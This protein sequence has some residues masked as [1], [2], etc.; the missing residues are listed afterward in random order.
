MIQ[1]STGVTQREGTHVATV[2]WQPFVTSVMQLTIH[3]Y[4]CEKCECVV[5]HCVLTSLTSHT[6]ITQ[7]MIC[8]VIKP[9]THTTHTQLWTFVVFLCEN[10]WPWNQQDERNI[11]FAHMEQFVLLTCA[12]WFLPCSHHLLWIR[13]HI[14][15]F[16]LLQLHFTDKLPYCN[17]SATNFKGVHLTLLHSI[18]QSS[19]P[20]R[21]LL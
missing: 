10:V 8:Q 19:L 15:D 21:L 17:Y 13:S 11:R 5:L 2:A 16:T 7:L 4:E 14:L 12:T 1:V 20:L 9:H 18:V 3:Q 6:Y